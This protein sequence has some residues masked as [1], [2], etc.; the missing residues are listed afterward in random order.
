[1]SRRPPISTRTDTLFPYTRL[2]RSARDRKRDCRARFRENI[3]ACVTQSGIATRVECAGVEVD[4]ARECIDA[5]ESQ[6]TGKVLRQAGG[7]GN[8]R[9]DKDRKSTRLTSSH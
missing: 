9:I 2:F 4:V 6:N 7:A 1:M 5:V 8:S 3:V